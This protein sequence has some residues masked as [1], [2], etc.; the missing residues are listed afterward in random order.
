MTTGTLSRSA[1][2]LQRRRRPVGPLPALLVLLGGT[3]TLL[4]AIGMPWL[5][6]S[7][8]W[9]Y[10]ALTFDAFNNFLPLWAVL[11]ALGLALALLRRASS[12]FFLAA[13]STVLVV[14]L[15]PIGIEVSRKP[16]PAVSGSG[17]AIRLLQFNALNGNTDLDAALV[18]A[19]YSNADLIMV[20]EPNDFRS[21]EPRLHA[22]YPYQTPCPRS[23]DAVIY[24]RQRPLAADYAV[25][26]GMLDSDG[27]PVEDS[28]LGY[29]SM[30]LTGPDG[31]PFTAVTTHVSWPYPPLPAQHQRDTLLQRIAGVDRSRAVLTGDFN[32]T[33][34]TH[35][36]RAF[37]ERIQPMQRVTRALF[38]FPANP[39]NTTFSAPLPFLPIDHVYA[40]SRWRL[41]R[42]ERGPVSGSDHYPVIVDLVMPA[43]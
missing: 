23:C 12:R 38:S 40:G 17:K 37:D 26:P 28:S 4:G 18:L 36:M 25:V 1:P 27:H 34:W 10:W 21:L 20:Q 29:A 11:I 39:R 41:V 6:D 22:A 2:V 31:E 13:A 30:S 32:L 9:L 3:C 42:A 15:V 43:G 14:A 33:P 35:S 5:F 16:D 8:A 7:D 19:L 24:S